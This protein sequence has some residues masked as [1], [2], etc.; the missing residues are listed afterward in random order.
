MFTDGIPDTN[1]YRRFRIKAAGIP[2]DVAMMTEVINRRFS[3][4]EWP[5]PNLLVVDGGKGQVTAAKHAPV[6]VVGLAKRFE[7]IIVPEGGGFRVLRLSPSSPALQLVQ[8]IRDEAHRFAKRYHRVLR[9]V[10]Q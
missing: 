9:S 4:P 2:N 10:Y 3:H 1:E 6:P 8:H 7:E 5:F